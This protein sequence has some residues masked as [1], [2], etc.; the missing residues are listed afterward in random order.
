MTQRN[1]LEES[2][3]TTHLRISKKNSTLNVLHYCITSCWDIFLA[4]T[5]E[6][7]QRQV[8]MKKRSSDWWERIVSV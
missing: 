6:P 8:S 5:Y 3:N 7:I 2:E 1:R 4:G